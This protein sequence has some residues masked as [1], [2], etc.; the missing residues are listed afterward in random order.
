M[1]VKGVAGEVVGMA[2]LNDL[3]GNVEPYILLTGEWQRISITKTFDSQGTNIRTHG[4]IIRG[5]PGVGVYATGDDG[6]LGTL[7]TWANYVYVWG[8]QVESGFTN[9][10]YIPTFGGTAT[11][12]ADVASSSAYTRAAEKVEMYNIQNDWYNQD[13]GTFYSDSSALQTNGRVI[14]VNYD[15]QTDQAGGDTT[16]G[17]LILIHNTNTPLVVWNGSSAVVVTGPNQIDTGKMAFRYG[18]NDFAV[19]ANGVAPETDTSGNVPLATQLNIGGRGSDT[20]TIICGHVRAIRY[21]D[22]KLTDA[23]LQ[24]LTEN[25]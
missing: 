6:G 12:S 24:A 17:S 7:G 8:M 1:W 19:T 2:L 20:D 10:S 14:D 25:N 4:V 15:G 9:T 13:E 23:E 16:K 22:T 3:G 21:Y 11:R 5:A 18:V